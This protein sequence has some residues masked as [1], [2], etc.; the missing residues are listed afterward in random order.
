M[1]RGVGERGRV[2]ARGVGEK[3]GVGQKE[4]TSEEL[5]CVCRTPYYESQ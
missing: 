2:R 5:Y 4:N 1:G 3:G